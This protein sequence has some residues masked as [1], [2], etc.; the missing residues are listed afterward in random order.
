M[1]AIQD[2]NQALRFVDK[3]S[4]LPTAACASA[5]PQGDVVTAETLM[6]IY[7]IEARVEKCSL[8]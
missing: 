5:A 7:R 4:S 6:E 3:S 1:I 2:L 8:E